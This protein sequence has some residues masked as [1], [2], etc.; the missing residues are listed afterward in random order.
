[1]KH[2][3]ESF[4]VPF[5]FLSTVS[6]EKTWESNCRYQSAEHFK[7]QYKTCLD[8]LAG[9]CHEL[10]FNK[11]TK[12]ITIIVANTELLLWRLEILARVSKQ[13]EHLLQGRVTCDPSEHINEEARLWY[14]KL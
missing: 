3:N 2:F 10:V 1:M 9:A 12:R 4:T 13:V 6:E 5:F 14:N 7:T 8:H 11:E